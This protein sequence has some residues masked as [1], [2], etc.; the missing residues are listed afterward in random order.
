MPKLSIIISCYYNEENIPVT[1]KTLIEN[2][3][4]FPEDVEF[5]YVMIDDG[6]G[7]DTMGALLKFQEQY[8]EKVKVIKLAKNVGSH[9]ATVSGMA[10]ATGD[11]CVILSADLQDPPELIA[12]MYDYWAKGFKFVIANRS[13]RQESW[14]QKIFSNTYHGLIKRFALKNIPS[15][16][17]DFILFDQELNQHVVNINEKNT[18]IIYLMTWLGYDYVN[19]PYVR[20]KR[21]IGKSRWTFQ[22]KVKLFVDSFVAFS[23]FPVRLISFLGV[24]VGLL[25]IIYGVVIFVLAVLGKIEVRGWP[26]LMIT[27]LFVSSF[28]MVALGILGEYIW[29]VLDEV[30]KRPNFVVEKYYP[31]EGEKPSSE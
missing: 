9:N 31:L 19:I 10:R 2:E 20:R 12:K 28:Q 16:G 13:D 4:N 7:D 22:K 21:E 30:R 17:Y 25:A 8:P 3:A 15:G 29:R 5:E 24:F 11:C 27:L 1:S 14:G 26:T 23:F 6:S 18:N